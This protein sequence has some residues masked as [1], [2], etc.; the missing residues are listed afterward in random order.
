MWIASASAAMPTPQL[1]DSG[2]MVD[3]G[4]KWVKVLQR[5]HAPDLC[6]FSN[7][8]SAAECEALVEA[9]KPRLLR[10]RTVDTQTG[11]E[12]L[13][14]DRTSDG[15]FFT[16][17]E[18]A[19][20][21]RVESRVARLLRWPLQNFEGM[22]VLRYRSGAQYKPHY[23]YFDPEEPATPALLTRGGQRVATLIMYLQEPERG[24]ATLFPDACISVPPQRGSAVFFSYAQA[25]PD[26]LSLHGGEPVAAGE[27]WIATLWLRQRQ[28]N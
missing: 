23:D 27:K 3:A 25:H 26:S 16:R 2:T 28:F 7:L 9:A 17:A 5:V 22:Q 4:D 13:N 11:G 12:A 24:G 6:V 10:S 20:V 19:T 21:Q 8:L 15:M 1:D 14:R 18:N